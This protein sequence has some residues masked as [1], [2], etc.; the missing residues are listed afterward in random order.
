MKDLDCEG[1]R[2]EV[3]TRCIR[4]LESSECWSKVWERSSR[5]RVIVF[6]SELNRDDGTRS[7][8]TFCERGRGRWGK[9]L[10]ISCNGVEMQLF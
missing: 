8:A 6:D 7:R 9:K 2:E 10:R 3:E 4:K 5:G 1:K